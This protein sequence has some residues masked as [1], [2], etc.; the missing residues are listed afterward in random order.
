M[1]TKAPIVTQLRSWEEVNE[2]LRAIGEIELEVEAI[3]AELT[4]RVNELK[5]Q[6][7]EQAQPLLARK[8]RLEGEVE[9]FVGA[10]V[11]ELSGKSRQL[12][13]G[14]VGFRT[15][16]SLVLRNVNRMIEM[17]KARG[18]LDCI[19]L[20]ETVNKT[21]LERYSDETLQAVGARRVSR[22]QFYIEV[23]RERVRSH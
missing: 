18:M 15:V 20:K 16:S 22:E 1:A 23:D 10:H 5:A 7:D 8:K 11:E 13:F 14:K 2:H 9:E 19:S 17:L 12:T 6:A 21:A 3:N 4:R